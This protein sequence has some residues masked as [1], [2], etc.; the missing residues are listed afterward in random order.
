MGG[1]RDGSAGNNFSLFTGL[2]SFQIFLLV[3]HFTNWTGNN[4]LTDHNAKLAGHFQNLVGR[5]PV[6]DCYFQDCL[7]ETRSVLFQPTEN[8][9]LKGFYSSL[10]D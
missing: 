10:L 9:F 1:V 2:L 7:P 3:K 5:C 4:L 8:S 6:T